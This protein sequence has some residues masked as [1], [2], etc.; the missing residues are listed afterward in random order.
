M[1]RWLRRT[2]PLLVVITAAGTLFS[3]ALMRQ[4]TP[5]YEAEAVL[6]WGGA[7]PV[8]AAVPPSARDPHALVP[9]VVDILAE[10]LH[11]DPLR[12]RPRRSALD[13]VISL[14]GLDDWPPA[15]PEPWRSAETAASD[16]EVYRELAA[17][18]VR[19]RLEIEPGP[20]LRI[21]YAAERPAVAAVTV[22]A[23]ADRIILS[24]LEASGGES[25]EGTID[26]SAPAAGADPV[27]WELIYATDPSAPMQ[28]R[29]IVVAAAGS[30][31]SLIVA[32]IVAA[33][34]GALGAGFRSVEQVRARTGLE[35]VLPMPP[36]R[37][38]RELSPE[39][40]LDLVR[41]ATSS[42][43]P[44]LRGL[45]AALHPADS[46]PHGRVVAVTSIGAREGK[47]TLALAL[48]RLGAISGR[49][50]LLIDGA[51]DQASLHLALGLR[52]RPGLSECLIGRAR[53]EDVLEIDQPSGSHILLAGQARRWRLFRRS[54]TAEFLRAL[55]AVYDLVI[56]DTEPVLS[57]PR[58]A[59]LAGYADDTVLV[60][61]RWET[62]RRAV[63]AGLRRLRRASAARICIALTGAKTPALGRDDPSHPRSSGSGGVS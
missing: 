15:V 62:R 27:E 14:I 58:A 40:H 42:Y 39:R 57:S 18:A 9:E 53:L 4:M 31:S 59:V 63:R 34:V 8:S 54:A 22:N 50:V 26:R 5:L 23:L 30:L 17:I 2:G 37:P 12:T 36:T 55:A 1:I 52:K 32:L 10:E 24:W 51:A 56:L 43:L 7:A 25:V 20:P 48:A 21:S 19:D 29:P 35:T 49:R 28:P 41:S 33:I 47:T 16:P 45:L 11:H 3:I 6:L 38:V 60:V 13:A 61:R 46:V 44:G